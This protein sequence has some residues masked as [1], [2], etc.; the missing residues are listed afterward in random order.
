LMCQVGLN[1]EFADR[2]FW[3]KCHE[4]DAEEKDPH[5]H[6][7][8]MRKSTV[9]DRWRTLPSWALDMANEAVSSSFLSKFYKPLVR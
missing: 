3:F 7:V 9:M 2:D 5:K 6:S 1:P 4:V 8:F